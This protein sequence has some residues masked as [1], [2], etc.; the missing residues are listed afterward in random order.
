[1]ARNAI[2]AT[3][4]ARRHFVAATA[5]N[6]RRHAR[7]ILHTRGF[8]TLTAD[9]V[10]DLY[11]RELRAYKPAALKATDAEGHVQK[12]TMPKL[13]KSP[14]ETSLSSQMKEYED[15]V[16]EVEGQDSSGDAQAP[17]GDYFEDLK[18]FDEKP[19]AAAH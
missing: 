2:P 11:L 13:P 12:F 4:G 10:Q 16:V 9:I 6:Q 1:V 17:E 7:I 5:L 19:T 15:S 3:P 8:L 18:D 14:E